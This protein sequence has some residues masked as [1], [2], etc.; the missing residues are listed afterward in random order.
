M[1][2]Q[3]P[4]LVMAGEAPALILGGRDGAGD[5]LGASETST[6]GVLAGLDD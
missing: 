4:V 6:L 1:E 3:K 2:Y 5:N